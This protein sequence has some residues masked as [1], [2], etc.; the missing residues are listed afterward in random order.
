MFMS[1]KGGKNSD[2]RGLSAYKIV[3]NVAL[4]SKLHF[5]LSCRLEADTAYSPFYNTR[6]FMN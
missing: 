5:H 6:Y 2:G 1:N 4:P 3:T